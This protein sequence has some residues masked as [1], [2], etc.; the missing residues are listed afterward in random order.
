MMKLQVSNT[1]N[2]AQKSLNFVTVHS[3]RDSSVFIYET[4]FFSPQLLGRDFFHQGNREIDDFQGSTVVSMRTESHDE[5]LVDV[6]IAT[7]LCR[8]MIWDDTGRLLW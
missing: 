2:E 8:P 5:A 4:E 7:F 1:N 6:T 3:K